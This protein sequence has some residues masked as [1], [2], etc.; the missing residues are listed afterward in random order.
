MQRGR[1]GG[2]PGA[3][4]PAPALDACGTACG[5]L[6]PGASRRKC[7]LFCRDLRS[8]QAILLCIGI[9]AF[10]LLMP[11]YFVSAAA[12]A[13]GLAAACTVFALGLV[14]D[15]TLI[16][17]TRR[18]ADAA[19]AASPAL[20]HALTARISWRWIAFALNLVGSALLL[21]GCV[22]YIVAAGAQSDAQ[23]IASLTWH[24]NAA[25]A[26]S[27]WVFTAGFALLVVDGVLTMHGVARA[28]GAPE[29]GPWDETK[30]LLFAFLASLC[31]LTIGNTL[32][33]RSGA[34]V[35]FVIVPAFGGG[36]LGAMACSAWQLHMAWRD[37]DFSSSGAA[38]WDAENSAAQST[39][40]GTAELRGGGG[41]ERSSGAPGGASD[42]RT[43]LLGG[44]PRQGRDY[45]GWWFVCC[46]SIDER[47][48][49]AAGE[50][51]AA[52]HL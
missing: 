52:S 27:M 40:F 29:P 42:A 21:P 47:G 20:A 31:G 28:T 39:A 44:P 15:V 51:S 12:F 14:Y 36:A 33:L 46:G 30:V 10:A 19:R 25:F 35:P 8:Q 34:W 5:C 24:A 38:P 11:V 45:A 4:P 37:F 23:R 48:P 43:P 50:G 3:P 26:A 16:G 22:L 41:Y 17:E 13:Y 32:V 2:A 9:Y 6:F 7:A 49:T 18:A 1:G